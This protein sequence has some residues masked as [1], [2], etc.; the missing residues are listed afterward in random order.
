LKV[1]V[2][3]PDELDEELS[4]LWSSFQS[5]SREWEN[6]FFHP[7]FTRAVAAVRDDVRIA[8]LQE[9]GQPAGF[10]P[11]QQ[12]KSRG[13]P[14]GHPVSDAHDVIHRPGLRFDV[15]K[16]LRQ[17]GLRC[18]S[19][20]HLP[21]S[22]R[23]FL[24]YRLASAESPVMNLEGGWDAYVRK[25]KKRSSK[26]LGSTLKKGRK[27]GRNVGELRLEYHTSDSAVFEALLAWKA[28]QQRETGAREVLRE[29]WIVELL[30]R[31][32]ETREGTFRGMLSAL[33]A[34]DEIIAA[35][36]GMQNAGM[37][38][39]WFQA[40][41][42]EFN[43]YSPGL[44]MLTSLGALCEE[45]GFTRVD[46]GKG[47]ETYKKSFQSEAIPLMEG[48]VDRNP[49]RRLLTRSRYLGREWI[50]SS[51]LYGTAYAAKRFVRRHD[52]RRLL[53]SAPG[54]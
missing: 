33:Y 19:F 4:S 46:L 22:Q 7:A 50:R 6:P 38:H 31:I 49:S 9:R 48:S 11:F 23:N 36:L 45:E 47:P 43:K 39:M 14:V 54:E 44:V 32:R 28:K 3:R 53:R 15:M 5:Q 21:A 41:N 30:D 16:L 18:W 8:V 40:Y 13:R 42:R 51:S 52:P 37:L 1:D 35:H 10:F 34:G 29:P 27:I 12:S 17:S 26:V 24:P 20:D 25:Q 2:L